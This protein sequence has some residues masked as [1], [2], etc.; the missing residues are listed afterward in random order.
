MKNIILSPWIAGVL[1]GAIGAACSW[2]STVL[3][4]EGGGGGRLGGMIVVGSVVGVG[5]GLGLQSKAKK[6]SQS[7]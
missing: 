6:N 2:I 5:T 1:A 3:F 4:F 7:E